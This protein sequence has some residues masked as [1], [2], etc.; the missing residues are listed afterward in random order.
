MPA[1]GPVTIE[2]KA[3]SS[4]NAQI[5]G[6]TARRF[7]LLPDEDPVELVPGRQCCPVL[8]PGALIF[9]P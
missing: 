3:R 5:H 8:V 7:E 9:A 4:M 2:G 1:T 6:L